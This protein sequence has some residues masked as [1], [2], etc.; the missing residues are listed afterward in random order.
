MSKISI[1]INIAIYILIIITVLYM[2]I[3]IC[4]IIFDVG[5]IF[6]ISK[7]SKYTVTELQSL[8]LKKNPGTHDLLQGVAMYRKVFISYG[9]KA[10]FVET[11]LN[12]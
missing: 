9:E 5:N 12:S 11:H 1:Y 2:T 10:Y 4:K 7:F 3:N 8:L 6:D